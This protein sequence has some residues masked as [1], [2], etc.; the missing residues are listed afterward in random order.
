[1]K[2][3]PKYSIFKFPWSIAVR[4]SIRIIIYLY[5]DLARFDLWEGNLRFFYYF[6][7]A[8]LGDGN[9]VDLGRVCHCDRTC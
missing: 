4:R 5:D 2:L 6:G 8:M 3:T 7:P 1:M 9:G